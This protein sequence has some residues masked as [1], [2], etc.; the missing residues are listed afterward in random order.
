M[1][2]CV[3]ACVR[4]WTRQ[5]CYGSAA[6]REWV[7]PV[8][9]AR[10]GVVAVEEHQQQQQQPGPQ[11]KSKRSPPP[12]KYHVFADYHGCSSPDGMHGYGVRTVDGVVFVN[13]SVA[14]T[15]QVLLVCCSSCLIYAGVSECVR[16]V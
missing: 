6:L 15:S 2:A 10:D 11:Q 14:Y 13:A 3:R 7:L 1:S 5:C 12:C 8:S 16:A 9:V 4:S